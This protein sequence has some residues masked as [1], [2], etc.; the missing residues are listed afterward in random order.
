MEVLRN[1]VLWMSNYTGFH[2]TFKSAELADFFTALFL[3]AAILFWTFSLYILKEIFFGAYT[4]K[5][6]MAKNAVVCSSKKEQVFIR[7]CFKY[8]ILFNIIDLFNIDNDY[9]DTYIDRACKKLINTT[10][11]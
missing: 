11:K 3:G 8:M 6:I 5:Y 9:I 10:K 4:K 1:I 7:R 2:E